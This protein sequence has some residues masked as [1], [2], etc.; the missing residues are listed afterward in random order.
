MRGINVGDMVDVNRP[1][2]FFTVQKQKIQENQY[3]VPEIYH[4]IEQIQMGFGFFIR[5][6]NTEKIVKQIRFSNFLFFFGGK[7]K[8][9]KGDDFFHRENPLSEPLPDKLRKL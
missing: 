7:V 8:I 4:G 3:L 6:V 9:R 1:V 5:T 2:H